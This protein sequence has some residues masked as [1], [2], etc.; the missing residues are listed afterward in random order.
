MTYILKGPPKKSQSGPSPIF[1]SWQDLTHTLWMDK[2]PRKKPWF[3]FIPCNYQQ[4]VTMASFR[5]AHSIMAL[6]SSGSLLV[7]C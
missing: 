6:A 1:L 7:S 3:L 5:G 2:T 4:F